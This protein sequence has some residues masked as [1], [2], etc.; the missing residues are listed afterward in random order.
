MT[1]QGP[2]VGVGI[3]SL[4]VAM[5]RAAESEH[6]DRL[7][8]DHLA[9][10]FLAAAPGL[11]PESIDPVGEEEKSI[12]AAFVVHA[13]MRTRFYDD[14]LVAAGETGVRQVVLVA[15]GL[16]ARAFRLAWPQDAHLYEI[17]LPDVLAFKQDVLTACRAIPTCARTTV[18]VDLREN[19][20]DALLR[21]GFDPG[22]PTAWLMEGLLVYLTP[23]EAERLLSGV[24]S[25]ST[26]GSQ[27]SF[28]DSTGAAPDIM[29]RA[30]ATPGMHR[31]TR[32]FRG[33]LD[34]DPAEWL[35][36]H[37]WQ[38]TKHRLDDLAASYGRP[39]TGPAVSGFLT[40]VRG[41][42]APR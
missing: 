11:V 41:P 7:F 20:P 21:A 4:A 23:Q 8:D 32:L 30:H 33:G 42:S 1:E 38:P 31:Y 16:D 36:D 10:A 18:P 13:I 25:L 22:L 27:V 9:A 39:L 12:A 15:A 26:A 29:A 34:V 37:G 17:D 6:P 28:E 35:R 3:T 14:Y 5:V 2:L 40:A 24:D 19:W